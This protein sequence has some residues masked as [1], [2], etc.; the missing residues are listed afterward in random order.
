MSA[1]AELEK[2]EPTKRFTNRVAEYV[3]FRPDYPDELL[4]QLEATSGVDL[5]GARIA[6]LGSGT[7]IMT[8]RLLERGAHVRAVEPNEAMRRAAEA[9]LGERDGFTSVA[10]EAEATGLPRGQRRADR[11][12][13]GLPLVRR[14]RPPAPSARACSSPAGRSRWCGTRACRTARRFCAATR[15]F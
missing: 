11:G 12:R 9:A 2:A 4:D 14:P 10:A 13:P 8:A 5:D 3:R 15:P 6:D 7:G 1:P